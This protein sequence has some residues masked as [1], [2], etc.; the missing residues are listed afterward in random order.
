MKRYRALSLPE[1]AATKR[2]PSGRQCPN[3]ELGR[4]RQLA[5]LIC[6]ECG[7]RPIGK[8]RGRYGR[9]PV[10]CHNSECRRSHAL[11]RASA[12]HITGRYLRRL[13]AGE[14]HPCT[15]CGERTT[16]KRPTC[17]RGRCVKQQAVNQNRA[18]S[19]RAW[20]REQAERKA[21]QRFPRTGKRSRR[22]LED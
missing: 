7:E 8:R 14:S 3:I 2:A 10:T 5:G 4:E 11:A 13:R 1:L 15:I 16:N 22:G 18:T 12:T 17:G 21:R 9:P 20:R 6:A 19:L